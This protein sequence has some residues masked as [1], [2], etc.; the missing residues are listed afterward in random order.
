ML[1]MSRLAVKIVILFLFWPD[2]HI[3]AARV[4]DYV[5]IQCA[6]ERALHAVI[7]ENI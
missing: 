2:R 6:F 1:F 7:I 5:M 3:Q 4:S